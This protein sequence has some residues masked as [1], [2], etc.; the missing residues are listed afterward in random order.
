MISNGGKA[1]CERGRKNNLDCIHLIK[2]LTLK[3]FTI[4]YGSVS[5][6]QKIGLFL[7]KPPVVSEYGR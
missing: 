2:S 3:I 5:L 4:S 7:A 1:R 6:N